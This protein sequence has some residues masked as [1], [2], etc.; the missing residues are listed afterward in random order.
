MAAGAA[1]PSG[2]S[3]SSPSGLFTLTMQA[4]GTLALAQNN[5]SGSATPLWSSSGTPVAG[6]FAAMQTGGS[7][8]VV[9]APTTVTYTSNTTT[10]GTPYLAVQN[11]GN[12]VVYDNATGNAVWASDTQVA[13]CS[14]PG[15]GSSPTSTTPVTT[16]SANGC[17]TLLAA[18]DTQYLNG[19]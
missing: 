17:A 12:L 3:I 8:A 1:L 16:T 9:A 18:G 7:L 13:T 14:T 2:Q 10:T 15:P 5:A 6:A 4:G 11:D 19:T